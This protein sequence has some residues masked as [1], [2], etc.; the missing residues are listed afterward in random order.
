GYSVDARHRP[1]RLAGQAVHQASDQP[2]GSGM[3]VGIVG[4]TGQ[5]GAKML[6][7]LAERGFPVDELRLFASARSAGRKLEWNGTEITVEDAA[8]ADYSGL[9]IALF[10]AGKTTSKALAP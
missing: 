8:E 3:R 1:G 2:R 10:S 9:D 5:V 6:E 4:A 7:I